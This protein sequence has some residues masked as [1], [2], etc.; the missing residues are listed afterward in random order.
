MHT[1]HAQ[2]QGAHTSPTLYYCV[3]RTGDNSP[4]LIRRRRSP[5]VASCAVYVPVV[6]QRRR[7]PKRLFFRCQSS[8]AIP[9]VCQRGTR[10]EATPTFEIAASKKSSISVV[11]LI[12]CGVNRPMTCWKPFSFITIVGADGASETNCESA[13]GCAGGRKSHSPL[14]VGTAVPACVSR[15]AAD[16]AAIF[17]VSSLISCSESRR[18]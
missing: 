2:A 1:T 18:D 9:I 6:S 11:A 15:S 10:L 3:V 7:S 13:T 8:E 14:I 5:S 12:S 17:I 4:N 16:N